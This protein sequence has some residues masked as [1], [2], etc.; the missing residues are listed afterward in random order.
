LPCGGVAGA[1][2]AGG[3]VVGAGTAGAVGAGGGTGAT[4]GFACS[5]AGLHANKL[6]A[7]ATTARTANLF[8]ISPSLVGGKS[9]FK[10]REAQAIK[11]AHKL[12][13][14]FFT[15]K[16]PFFSAYHKYKKNERVNEGGTLTRPSLD[17]I[18]PEVAGTAMIK[19]R[20]AHISY[21]ILTPK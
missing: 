10:K 15:F 11:T 17:D 13:G 21:C 8:I 16:A 12:Q 5:V 14:Y 18:E 7:N 19:S 20:P 1:S 9:H 6:A 4:P 2:G 3:G